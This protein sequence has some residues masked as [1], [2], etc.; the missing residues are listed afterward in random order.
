[1]NFGSRTP[2]DESERIVRRALERGQVFFDTAN[3]YNDGE[4]ERILGRAIGKDRDR[5]ILATKVGY[6]R[7]QGKLEGLS[8]ARVL[9]A[10]EESLGRLGTDRVDLYYLHVP[11]R[12]TPIDETLDAIQEILEARKAIHWGVSNYASW[13]I[14]EMM[15]IADRRKMPRPVMSQQIYN[16]LIRQL[17]IEYFKFTSKHPIVTTVYN[18]LA[19][20]LLTGKHSRAAE[21]Q[22]GSRFENNRLYQGRYWNDATFDHVADLGAVAH[23]EKMS[24]G[25]LAYAW[26]ADRP[27]VDA[28]LVGPGSVQHLD[29]AIDACAKKISPEGKDR[30]ERLYRAWQG[31][32]V[33]YAR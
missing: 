18:P 27:G 15:Q 8:R 2:R 21:S 22:A 13:E 9:A 17:E 14:L 10:I 4:S 5:C 26:V 29:F 30:I 11:D 31:T 16:V 23:E 19:G 7:V 33:T 12:R 25:E 1:M 28:I 3:A 6:A 20:G 24:I 32:D